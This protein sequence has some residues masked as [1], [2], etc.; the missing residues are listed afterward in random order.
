M[1][2]SEKIRW[3][4]H[5]E[6]RR[7]L[8]VLLCQPDKDSLLQEDVV[9]RFVAALEELVPS[10]T[11]SMK[12]FSKAL[13]EE[14]Q[15]T[16]LAEY[17]R[18]FIGPDTLPAPP[19]GSV[20]LEPGRQVLGQTTEVVRKLYAEEG[21]A[22]SD[23]V[24]EPPDH[25]ALEFEFAAFILQKAA[26]ACANDR[27]TEAETL[28]QKAGDFEVA[29]LRSWL[30]DL[31]TAIEAVA[32]TAFYTGVARGLFAYCETEMPMLRASSLG[33]EAEGGS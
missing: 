14:A 8:A 16:L 23:E 11:E 3:S 21:L 15:D 12:E 25:I 6:V 20:H 5:L 2:Q 13:D 24:K 32:E 18:L 31:A 29:F 27:S 7:L 19:Y 9:P 1:S 10:S 30:P 17:T 28:L 26:A 22:V 33:C 4:A